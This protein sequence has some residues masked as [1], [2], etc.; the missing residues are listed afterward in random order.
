[1][2]YTQILLIATLLV[3]TSIPSYADQSADQK[4]NHRGAGRRECPSNI[5]H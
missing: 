2:K 5:N 3:F 4:C 1:M